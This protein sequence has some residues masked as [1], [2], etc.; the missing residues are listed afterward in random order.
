MGV[1]W[2]WGYSGNELVHLLAWCARQVKAWVKGPSFGR[3][4]QCTDASLCFGCFFFFFPLN[5]S[6]PAPYPADTLYSLTRVFFFVFVVFLINFTILSCPRD[7]GVRR[8]ADSAVVLRH[9]RTNEPPAETPLASICAWK[10]RHYSHRH[11][12]LRQPGPSSIPFL[13]VVCF[14]FL[15]ITHS[16]RLKTTEI[17]T[18]H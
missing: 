5:F 12:P 8:T 7:G 4:H 6:L 15:A 13:F 17:H 14:F 9:T 16:P 2:G 10:R 18:P 11:N 3:S 1:G